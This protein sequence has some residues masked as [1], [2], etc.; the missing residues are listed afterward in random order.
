M[1]RNAKHIL[2]L[3]VALPFLFH[4]CSSPFEPDVEEIS[5]PENEIIKEMDANNIP[6]LAAWIVKEDSIVWEKYYGYADINSNRL[7][8]KNTVYGIASISKL[9]IV[10]A[11]MQLYKQG[12]IE[13]HADINNYLP[14]EVSNPNYPDDKITPYHLLT[15]T[16]GLSWPKNDYEVPGYYTHYPLDSAPP[17]IEWLPQFIIPGGTY[18]A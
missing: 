12:L 3:L 9:V 17:L 14:F 5:N 2:I 8:D 1:N 16:S 4:R 10:T 11:V 13:L 18:Y 7:A 15:H 6:S